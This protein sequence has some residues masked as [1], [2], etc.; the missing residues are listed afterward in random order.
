LP[1]AR[2][3][4]INSEE[5]F[6][7][8]ITSKHFKGQPLH[9]SGFIGQGGKDHLGASDV[10]LLDKYSGVAVE[11][12][13]NYPYGVEVSLIGADVHGVSNGV[14][15]HGYLDLMQERAT[16]RGFNWRNLSELYED[17]RIALP[18]REILRQ[19]MGGGGQW[20]EAWLQLPEDARTTL[21][22]QASRRS[23]NGDAEIDAFYYFVMR[24]QEEE[25]FSPDFEDSLFVVN[26]YHEQAKHFFPQTVPQMYWVDVR[27]GGR[28]SRKQTLPPPWFRED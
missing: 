6:H 19:Q 7:R 3:G 17:K 15:D 27:D 2:I 5:L 28:K 22:R 14:A 9:V 13:K 26:G 11:L 16:T 20:H 25:I 1:F 21:I 24:K 8:A 4:G 18:D 23:V 12:S 10:A